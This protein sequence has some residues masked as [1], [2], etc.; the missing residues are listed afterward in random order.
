MGHGVQ[1]VFVAGLGPQC[2]RLSF[3]SS[4]LACIRSNSQESFCVYLYIDAEPLYGYCAG[5]YHRFVSVVCTRLEDAKYC[6][7][8]LG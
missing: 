5:G 3:V 1:K 6:K 7:I 4:L 8:R 2:V